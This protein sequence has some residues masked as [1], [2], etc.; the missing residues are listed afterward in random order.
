[1]TPRISLQGI[2]S[3]GNNNDG[4]V[5]G[6]YES[7]AQFV[8]GEWHKVEVV[9]V[10][11]TTGANNGS[12]KLYLNGVLATSCSGIRFT[13]ASSPTWHLLSWSPTW[14]GIGGTVVSTMYQY[15]DH[16]YVSGKL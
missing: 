15:M 6:T 9:A 7:N 12:V 5:S 1:L 8:R 14:G 10:A 3:G 16:L 13:S 11:N 2:V 4:G